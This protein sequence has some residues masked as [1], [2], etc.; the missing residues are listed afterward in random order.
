M[1]AVM[2]H[3]HE[4]RVSPSRKNVCDLIRD[5]NLNA[6]VSAVFVVSFGPL[7][8]AHSLT[9]SLAHRDLFGRCRHAV[10][11]V[12]YIGFYPADVLLMV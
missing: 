9:H 8:C 11:V 12:N 7:T 4:E 6:P 5:N 10:F 3:L 2:W 1:Y